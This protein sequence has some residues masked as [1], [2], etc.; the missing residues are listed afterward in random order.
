[1]QNAA[2]IRLKNLTFGYHLPDSFLS[3]LNVSS[4]SIYFTGKNLWTWSPMFRNNSNLDPENIE[5]SDPELGGGGNRGQGMAY[6]IL[7]TSSVRLKNRRV[8]PTVEQVS[9]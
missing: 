1:L 7:K 8:L 4:M 2:Y 6:P 5:R 3:N 9:P